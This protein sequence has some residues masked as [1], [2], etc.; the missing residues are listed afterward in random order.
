MEERRYERTTRRLPVRFRSRNQPGEAPRR[1]YT[2]NVSAGGMYVATTNPFPSGTVLRCYVGD[3]PHDVVLD[4]VV[5]HSHRIARELGTAV[6]TGGMGVRFYTVRE[7]LEQVNPAGVAPPPAAR[8]EPEPVLDSP[9]DDPP[10]PSPEA[11]AV[12]AP[13]SPA[14]SAPTAPPPTVESP[15]GPHG[16]VVPAEFDSVEAFAEV[17]RRD[18]SHGGLFVST[19]KPYALGETV[20]VEVRVPGREPVRL[21]AQVVHRLAPGELP[22]GPVGV[23]VQFLDKPAARD[24]LGRLAAQ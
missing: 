11:S 1:G 6:G 17:Y 15:G 22:G 24:I 10:P 18:A 14:P 19:E 8:S 4:G 9:P 21:A 23:G 13:S 2:T 16:P 12:G 20:A 5:A 3:G 7:L